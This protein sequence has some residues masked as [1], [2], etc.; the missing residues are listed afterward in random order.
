VTVTLVGYIIDPNCPEKSNTGVLNT[1][2]DFTD[3]VEWISHYLCSV[4][5]RFVLVIST[6]NETLLFH[7]P[8]GFRTVYYTKYQGKI[9][10]GSQPLIFK[11]VL[12]LEDGER[13]SSYIG[14]SYVKT[15]IE[16]WIPSGCS[17]FEEVYHLVPNH[18]L[19]LS[20]LE[21]IRY[22]PRWVFPQKPVSEVVAEASDL[23]RRLMLAASNR[24]KLALP[25]TAGWD[26][27]TILS[28][29][30]SIANEM[31]FFTLQ[32]RDLHPQSNDIKISAKLLH[33]LGL[34]HNV[35]DCGKA[36]PEAFRE[37]YQRNAMPT[38]M[39]DWGQMAYA[40][41][42]AYP[43]DRVCVK[44]NCSEIARC[45]YYKDG[46][47]PPIT[48]PDQII[49]LVNGWHTIPFIREQ[50]STWYDQASE[51][52]A[53]ANMDILDLFYWE[54]RMGSWQAQGQLEWDIVQ[55]AF[56]PFNHRG[57]LELMLSTPAKLRSAPDYPL[58]QMMLK[59]LWPEVL[60]QPVNPMTAKKRL[61]K[62]LRDITA[63]VSGS[64]RGAIL[65]RRGFSR[66]VA[67]QGNPFE[68]S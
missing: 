8:C 26:S 62:L 16:H 20:T 68:E 40:M 67:R 31:Y 30:K 52:A 27:R 33:S 18:Y 5:G 24:F 3:S 1:I 41:V 51:V 53:E 43:Q 58:Y 39:D 32:Y 50:I 42:D 4:S 55:E 29:S 28:A 66:V 63:P 65:G 17:L 15:Q 56:T 10:I 47:H 45:F 49:A 36:A 13:L 34:G 23:L 11:Q 22:W 14:S 48:S 2:A 64:G 25:L 60:R 7:D 12:P 44:G 61:T 19:R 37:M 21:Q 38:H 6:P 54:H 35:I 57:L 9:F 59:V 46:T